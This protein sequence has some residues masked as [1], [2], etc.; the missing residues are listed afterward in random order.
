MGQKAKRARNVEK[1]YVKQARQFSKE[2]GMTGEMTIIDDMECPSAWNLPKKGEDGKPYWYFHWAIVGNCL[3]MW[4]HKGMST[5]PE[6]WTS[7]CASDSAKENRKNEFREYLKTAEGKAWQQN[8]Q[9]DW[10]PQSMPTGGKTGLPQVLTL[11]SIE[12]C[13]PKNRMEQLHK[14][15]NESNSKPEDTARA[16]IVERLVS[17][18]RD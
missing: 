16:W 4:E 15:A 6:A 3:L 14:L 9:P 13:L 10:L 12:V 18:Y 5:T 1:D 17:I 7:R 8:H 11:E 2:N